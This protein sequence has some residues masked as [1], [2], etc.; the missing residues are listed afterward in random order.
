MFLS[1]SRLNVTDKFSGKLSCGES[2][3]ARTVNPFDV[4]VS[5]TKSESFLPYSMSDEKQD[6]TAKKRE[7]RKKISLLAG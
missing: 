7:K 2:F 4:I 3:P 1:R 6:L 5:F